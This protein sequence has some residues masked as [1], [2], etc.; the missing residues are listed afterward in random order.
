MSSP[1]PELELLYT[2]AYLQGIKHCKEALD[3]HDILMAISLINA[4]DKENKNKKEELEK[5][6][7]GSKQ[8]ETR[9]EVP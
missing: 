6:I 1:D 4:Y 9:K 2:K 3:K 5:E 7:N 8:I